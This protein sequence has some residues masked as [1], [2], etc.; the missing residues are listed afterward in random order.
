MLRNPGYR[1]ANRPGWASCSA[2]DIR[3]RLAGR[4]AHHARYERDIRAA[5]L[6]EV[7]RVMH[8]WRQGGGTRWYPRIC[9]GRSQPTGV[10]SLRC[11]DR[12]GPAHLNVCPSTRVNQRSR[13]S[14]PSP[15]TCRTIAR[16]SIAAGLTDVI[17]V[18]P[19]SYLLGTSRRPTPRPPPHRRLRPRRA[20]SAAAS[21]TPRVAGL[22]PDDNCDPAITPDRDG[23][24]P[25]ERA[26][27][28]SADSPERCGPAVD[29]FGSL[30]GQRW[31]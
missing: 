30:P 14:P 5:P 6:G 7:V 22:R 28:S 26:S 29:H 17:D 3:G 21:C 1:A 11:L 15:P 16:R 9:R 23:S 20:H 31:D 18:L 24:W 12:S 2:L 13:P 25:P 27:L 4:P 10:A 19:R 8:L